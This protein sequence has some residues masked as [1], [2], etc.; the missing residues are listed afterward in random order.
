MFP[1]LYSHT[2]A[3]IAGGLVIVHEGVDS[4]PIVIDTGGCILSLEVGGKGKGEGGLVL[5]GFQ[6]REVYTGNHL[7]RDQE[8]TETS[9]QPIRTRYLGHVTTDQ[10]IRDQYFLIRSVPGR[11][12]IPRI[13][14][15]AE[16]QL[17][18]ALYRFSL[19][20]TRTQKKPRMKNGVPLGHSCY[21][22]ISRKGVF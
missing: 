6:G 14:F 1:I 9:K 12:L 19:T 7:G 16:Q 3:L 21:S 18:Q 2:L 15:S 13:F 8:P 22:R 10:P 5:F 17:K 11:D 20:H 4:C